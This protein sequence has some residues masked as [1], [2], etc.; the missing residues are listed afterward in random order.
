MEKK[1]V[2]ELNAMVRMAGVLILALF[3]FA[4]CDED[5]EGPTDS[6]SL[7]W[8]HHYPVL[9]GNKLH[10]VAFADGNEGWIVGMEGV[11][12]HTSDGGNNWSSQKSGTRENLWDITFFDTDTG[13]AVG[14]NG[15]LMRT[16]NGGAVWKQTQFDTITGDI[17][18]VAF[19]DGQ[20]GWAVGEMGTVVRTTDGGR[21]WA[22]E[23]SGTDET[24]RSAFSRSPSLE[25]NER[26]LWL[27]AVGDAGTVVRIWEDSDFVGVLAR[28]IDTNDLWAVAL[29]DSATGWAVGENGAIWSTTD[30]GFTWSK[31]TSGV[32]ETLTDV[33]FADASTGVVV[34]SAGTILSTSDGG[35]TWAVDTSA[36]WHNLFGVCFASQTETW[37]VGSLTILHSTSGGSSWS[38]EPSGT[39]RYATLQDITFLNE[40]LGWAVGYAGAIL[41]TI[42]GGNTW[43]CQKR[44]SVY[45]LADVWY[46]DV[47]FVDS[48]NGWCVGGRGESPIGLL[49]HTSDGGKH[50]TAQSFD[51]TQRLYGI[52]FVNTDTGWAVGGDWEGDVGAIVLKT[53]D[54]GLTWI[55]SANIPTANRL[56]AVAFVDALNGWAVGCKATI[57]RTTDGGDS[58]ENQYTGLECDSL[59]VDT[60]TGDTVCVDTTFLPTPTL[61]AVAATDTLRCW[62]VGREG[63]IMYTSDGGTTWELQSSGT[64]VDLCAATFIDASTGWI[65]GDLGVILYTE[66]GG[67]TWSLQPSGTIGT[68][69]GVAFIDSDN[70]WIVGGDKKGDN[71][72]L[73]STTTGG[74]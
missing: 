10:A 65:T 5:G 14:E 57:L 35:E 16:I 34:G 68:L 44:E 6:I 71:I 27:L 15:R 51:S 32:S 18:G 4:G 13:W 1:A 24:L 25:G 9:E 58:W 69:L 56:E 66:D 47:T 7:A 63:S 39:A 49:L 29:V 26:N 64:T 52:T 70:G 40:D 54:A 60:L 46:Y 38:A 8:D 20:N 19:E 59:E 2:F 61:Y 23:T 33:V 37:A 22:R 72:I 36:T 28:T 73:L 11:V 21:S 12:L 42:D 17:Y 74:R 48:L 53:T 45:D 3:L 62:A 50:W 55:E 67:V 43:E 31:Q 41:R 30:G